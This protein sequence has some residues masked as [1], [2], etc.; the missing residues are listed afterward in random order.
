MDTKSNHNPSKGRNLSIALGSAVAGSIIDVMDVKS[1]ESSPGQQLGEMVGRAVAGSIGELPGRI[2]GGII[3]NIIVDA[4]AALVGDYAVK[5]AGQ[6]EARSL[7]RQPREDDLYVNHDLQKACREALRE[8][9]CD[10]GGPHCFPKAWQ[11]SR[12]PT[13]VE[14]SI[15]VDRYLAEDLA[16]ICRFF[17]KLYHRVDQIL[18]LEVPPSQLGDFRFYL[19][20]ESD[21]TIDF[22]SH[23]WQ[24]VIYPHLQQSEKDLL[25]LFPS[26]QMHLNRYLAARLLVHL[27][28]NLKEE[29]KAWRA[30]NRLIFNAIFAQLTTLQD[31][32]QRIQAQLQEIQHQ[33][34]AQLDTL[35]LAQLGAVVSQLGELVATQ[36]ERLEVLLDRALHTAAQT[37]SE[38]LTASEGRLWQAIQVIQ[39]SVA[40]IARRQQ[41]LFHQQQQIRLALLEP[42]EPERPPLPANFVGRTADLA[43]Y[44]AV[45]QHT[46][47][48]VVAGMAGVGKSALAARLARQTVPA[49]RIFWHTF[50]AQDDVHVLIE[51]MARFLAWQGR[52]EL[53]Y[54]W[55]AA[56]RF[57]VKEF[58]AELFLALRYQNYLLC[59]DDF[60][61]VDSFT[62]KKL[63]F[64]IFIDHIQQATAAG[65]LR[66]ILTSRHVPSFIKSGDLMTLAGL[67]PSEMAAF[68][69]ANGLYLEPV[70]MEKI[71]Q[72]TEGNLELLHLVIHILKDESEP[73]TL[74]DELAQTDD[75]ERFLFDKVD[76]GLKPKERKVM[77]GIA[78]LLGYPATRAA[79]EAVLDGTN[80][81]QALVYLTNHYLIQQSGKHNARLYAQHALVQ[82]H[83]YDSFKN[84]KQR[85]AL[86]RRA[87]IYYAETEVDPLKAIIHFEQADEFAYAIQLTITHVMP[88]IQRGQ[89]GIL[90]EMVARWR[91]TA[92]AL[93]T[94][95]ALTI[96][97]G[98]L[99]DALDER[100]RA[101][102]C[103]DQALI[104]LATMPTTSENQLLKARAY[105]G[106][107]KLFE[108]VEPQT[109][110]TW[111]EQGIA[112]LTT[113]PPLTSVETIQA[114]AALCVDLGNVR[115]YLGTYDDA[116]QALEEGLTYLNSPFT[117]TH[118]IAYKALSTIYFYKGDL[119]QAQQQAE[120]ALIISRQLGADFETAN[121]LVNLSS[122]QYAMGKWSDSLN[123]LQE[124]HKLADQLNSAEVKAAVAL[125]LGDTYSKLGEDEAAYIALQQSL[126]LTQR[127]HF[128]VLEIFVH[129]TLAS[130]HMQG[131]RWDD[132]RAALQLAEERSIEIDHK[133]SR[134]VIAS[135]RAELLL[136]N[137]QL[138]AAQ[139]QAQQAIDWAQ[140]TGEITDEGIARRILGQI[141]FAQQQLEPAFAAFEHSLTLLTAIDPYEVA[142][143][144]VQLGIAHRLNQHPAQGDPLLQAARATFLTLGA[145]RDLAK[146]DQV[147]PFLS[148]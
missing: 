146:L 36:T 61:H 121:L 34:S 18:P 63:P 24:A 10:I 100:E 112:I 70:A 140:T 101:Q 141:L 56:K 108:L 23:F 115:I 92:T 41:R 1:K 54:K 117:Q 102:A 72:R 132:A 91:T 43:R 29:E 123:S 136:A 62:H 52:P 53:W 17:D 144:K 118:C 134:T 111:L 25:G 68:L 7:P 55:Q 32:D 97:E 12:R 90:Q 21:A 74:L 110:A 35:D 33:L 6:L 16:E 143:T 40:E 8:S 114:L 67:D 116:I 31:N 124:A 3:E 119:A 49:D 30:F 75:I 137:K 145:R 120:S 57:S 38:Q 138:V 82:A 125:N 104:T 76:R 73:L 60:H 85:R 14:V 46:G 147:A 64:E 129:F 107:G 45:L 65:H 28:E 11:Q 94:V 2:L 22:R 113:A 37:L 13:P 48:V 86:H 96:T 80:V 130:L 39:Q 126:D 78:V 66:I 9:I 133:S 50:R 131:E 59:F 103:F 58:F 106:L 127:Y 88:I 51:H 4:R 93:P 20:A 69:Q 122:I 89:A 26:L 47:L 19:M 109:A 99:Q 81:K 98:M 15:P 128:A 142:R 83:Y 44:A 139:A 79:I 71:Y 87:G 95:V 77:E 105:H 27:G 42:A 135:L 148:Q 5:I 84:A